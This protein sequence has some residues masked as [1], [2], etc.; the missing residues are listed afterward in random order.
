[1]V[2]SSLRLRTFLWF[3]G[4]LD[5][6]LPF[7]QAT[8]GDGLV[9]NGVNR[10]PETG[11][12]F[13]ADLSIFGHEFIAMN[14]PGGPEFNEAISLSLETDGQAE[15]DHYWDALTRDGKAGQCGWCT[16]PFGV[17]WQVSPKQMR[18]WLEHPDPEVS[19]YANNALRKMNKIIIDDLHQ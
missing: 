15:T 10:N 13:T 12:L 4:T 16:D 18:D 9:V 11:S 19:S 7:Y 8:F 3:N 5:A 14:W 1:M 2:T 6:A 17:T